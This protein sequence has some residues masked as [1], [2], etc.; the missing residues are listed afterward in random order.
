MK[1]WETTVVA[2]VIP[3]ANAP[4]LLPL[5]RE[6]RFLPLVFLLNKDTGLVLAQLLHIIAKYGEF[7]RETS[8]EL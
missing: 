1:P 2:L 3:R 7:N 5:P 4:E 6:P 8:T